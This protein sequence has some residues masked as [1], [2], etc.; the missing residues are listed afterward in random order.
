LAKSNVSD[1]T[2]AIRCSARLSLSAFAS[3]P[4]KSLLGGFVA[5][6]DK[7]ALGTVSANV[8]IACNWR[9]PRAE[10]ST[11]S[12]SRAAKAPNPGF[13]AAIRALH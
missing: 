4:E 8:V 12:P 1:S 2:R 10:K 6:S 11:L 7:A 9:K 3:A 13:N 5:I